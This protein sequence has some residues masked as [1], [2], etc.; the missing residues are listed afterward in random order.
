MELV[1]RFNANAVIEPNGK[2]HRTACMGHHSVL[3]DVANYQDYVSKQFDN[4]KRADGHEWQDSMINDRHYMMVC[5]IEYFVDTV[6]RVVCSNTPT[7]QSVESL[8]KI[9]QESHEYGDLTTYRQLL[10][11]YNQL[12]K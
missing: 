3:C 2:I 5:G 9:I 10:E 12:L 1:K 4:G 11:I 7:P 6:Y 8:Y